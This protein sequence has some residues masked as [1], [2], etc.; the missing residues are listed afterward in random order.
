MTKKVLIVDDH[1]DVLDLL[2]IFLD[3]AGYEPLLAD[4]A[5]AALAML[6]QERP[7][8]IILDIMMPERSGIEVLENIRF[9]ERNSDIPVLCLSAAAVTGEARAFIDEFS[10]GLL[11]K[12]SIHTIVDHV[13]ELIGPP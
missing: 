3:R 1:R 12:R 4:G 13:R 7:D 8:A 10:A 11:D 6:E 9:S 2:K 5:F